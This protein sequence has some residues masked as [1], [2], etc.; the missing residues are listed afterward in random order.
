V[1]I[2]FGRLL[3]SSAIFFGDKTGSRWAR[4]SYFLPFFPIVRHLPGHP[5]AA[6][7]GKALVDVAAKR[8]ATRLT[9]AQ[10]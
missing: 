8:V 2:H 9:G 3:R 10:P 7:F 1:N 6:T 5:H 4:T